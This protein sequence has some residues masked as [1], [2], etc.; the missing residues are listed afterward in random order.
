MYFNYRGNWGQ[1]FASQ[2]YKD[3]QKSMPQMNQ[4]KFKNHIAAQ[5]KKQRNARSSSATHQGE[6]LRNQIRKRAGESLEG[7]S[8]KKRK[9]TKSTL[10]SESGDTLPKLPEWTP[11][12]HEKVQLLF[13]ATWYKGIATKTRNDTQEAYVRFS[14]I[15]PE[16]AS[17]DGWYPYD[18]IFPVWE[19]SEEEEEKKG[20]EEAEEAE[21]GKGDNEEGWEDEKEDEEWADKEEEDEEEVNNVELEE[22]DE[23]WDE[24]EDAEGENEKRVAEEKE[25]D[26]ME[27]EE[28]SGDPSTDIDEG[29]FN[30]FDFS[31]C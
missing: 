6:K 14:L 19:E 29:K 8:T 1:L 22:E 28:K 27:M 7:S 30:S 31:D 24:E 16:E 12:R 13:D 9:P 4:Q 26:N 25:L 21:E 18:D 2:V 20:E 10:S 15:D 23:S 17:D 11:R 5:K 3:W